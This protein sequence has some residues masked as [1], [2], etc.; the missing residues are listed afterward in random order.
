MTL[1]ELL[2]R[3]CLI[4]GLLG[5]SMAAAGQ[6]H[7][8]TSGRS[9]VFAGSELESYIR[10]LQIDGKAALYPWSV[11]SFSSKEIDRL[12]A[13]PSDHPWAEHYDLG[14][15]SGGGFTFDLL[16]PRLTTS[17]NSAFPWGANDG[18]VW[19]GRG[20]TASVRVGFAAGSGP[21]SLIVAPLAFIS[22][23]GAFDLQDNGYTGDLQFAD[24]RFPTGIDRPQR[25]GNRPYSRIDPGQ[26]T[27]R[28]DLPVVAFGAST[29][30]QYWGPARQHPIL[31]GNNAPGFPHLFL[32][33]SAPLNVGIAEIHG[34][35]V[36]GKLSQSDYTGITGRSRRRFMSGII[37]VISPKGVR[38]LE[39]GAARFFHEAWPAGGLSLSNF[40]KPFESILKVGLTG[41]PNLPDPGQSLDNQLASVF[42]RWVFPQS[43]LEVYAEYGRED[44]SWDLRDLIL[45]PDHSGGYMLGLT[46][47]LRS[48]PSHFYVIRAEA[49]NLQV[50]QLIRGRNEFPFYLHGPQGHTERG[51][52]LGAAAGYGGNA[53]LLAVDRYH[54]KGRWTAFWSR[55][56][57]QDIGS[58]WK[59]GVRTSPGFDV[60]HALGG[61]VV[62]FGE[63]FDITAGISGVY[64]LARNFGND[65]INLNAHF[66]VRSNWGSTRP[67]PTG[68]DRGPATPAAPAPDM[69]RWREQA[70]GNT[71]ATPLVLVND[72]TV[73]RDRLGELIGNVEPN[74]HLLRAPSQL[75][76]RIGNE[77]GPA[78]RVLAPDVEWVRNSDLAFS[79][80]QGT[81][82]AGR[83]NNMR[84]RA[85]FQAD[86]GRVSLIVAPEWTHSEN[87]DFD[88]PDP[89][90]TPALGGWVSRAQCV[91]MMG[92]RPHTYNTATGVCTDKS[93]SGNP[94]ADPFY[95]G[96]NSI[97]RPLRF[98]DT[99]FS[100]I[101]PGQST[102]AVHVGAATLGLSTENEW[103]GPGIRNAIVLSDNAPGFAHFFAR[104]GRPISTPVGTFNGRLLLGTLRESSYFDDLPA[105]DTRSF[106]GF[107]LTWQPPGLDELALG[108]TRAVY[109]PVDG[110]SDVLPHLF[111]VF[112]SFPERPDDRP[113]T[114]RKAN[115]DVT[116]LPDPMQR[117]GP[118][119]IYSLFGRWVFPKSGFELYGEYSRTEFPAS[120]RD[121]LEAPGHTQGYTLG[122]QWARALRGGQGAFR[123]QAEHTYLERSTTF[124]DRPVGTYYTSRRVAQGYTNQGRV[125]GAGIGP[126]SSS[127]WLA[128]D[129]FGPSWEV[130]LFGERIRWNNDALM[131]LPVIPYTDRLWCKHDVTIRAGI[132][133]GASTPIGR[134]TAS[135][136]TGKRLNVFFQHFTVCG[137]S[138][139]PPAVI[140]INNT[141]LELK[142]S[143]R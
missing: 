124:R 110:T 139:I 30:N 83:G 72:P 86:W 117:P 94:F 8:Q 39:L 81:L 130:G 34:R 92:S 88:F 27:L 35:L 9:E 24:G 26:S 62:R 93:K 25:F 47:T 128:L 80:N 76:P 46:K 140:D 13:Q 43:G 33:S 22:Q 89:R 57:R 32:G 20:F 98:G 49:M 84:L 65:V 122:L 68:E 79:L 29:A 87:G 95:V 91:A 41:D 85:G 36:W 116:R 77:T 63:R 74:Q 131:D 64:N 119:H 14:P 121:W 70:V 6:L 96:S 99:A 137:R 12:L 120:F 16:R 52:I 125:L 100:A 53:T 7:A 44:H 111:D 135:L 48:S 134:F 113:V 102:L 59:T 97:D 61:E 133:G 114:L 54:A 56:L 69:P 82:W 50:S 115:G 66:S 73:D 60:Q 109:R 51:Q 75:T 5:L 101:H 105:N 143:L 11:R 141:T 103:W 67:N 1:A 40:T 132:R 123:L 138:P 127:H 90:V 18:P 28:I 126:G 104:T 2:S 136:S 4:L 38:G 37:G 42:A 19:A 3:Y 112:L 106:S 31:L 142:Y 45:E 108:V 23:N 78:L 17:V 129:Y 21:V 71:R 15:S 58:F 55:E 107:A 10:L 118:D